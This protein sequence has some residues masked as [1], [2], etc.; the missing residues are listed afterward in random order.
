[1]TLLVYTYLEMKPE[2]MLPAGFWRKPD[3]H[4]AHLSPWQFNVPTNIL[5]LALKKETR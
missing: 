1:M 2:K 4:L 3:D 5:L